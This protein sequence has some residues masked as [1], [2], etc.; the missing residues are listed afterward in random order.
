MKGMRRRLAAVFA[1][2]WLAIDLAGCASSTVGGE[3]QQKLRDQIRDRGLDPE[4]IIVPFSL[5]PDMHAWLK[6]NVQHAG[7]Q[8]ERLKALLRTIV[9]SA[10]LGVSYQA[11]L[12]ITA[13]DVFRT[14]KANCLAFTNLFVG[15]ARELGVEVYFLLV[16]DLQ[17]F[18]REGDLVVVSDHMTAAFG[19]PPDR[20]VLD[21]TPGEVREYRET[22]E[23]TDLVAVAMYYTN[24]G[25]G[26][27]RSGDEPAALEWLETAAKL[28]PELAGAWTNLGVARRR[29]GDITGAEEA[30]RRALEADASALSAYQNLAALLR[31]RGQEQE[32]NE[33][34]A[35]TARRDNRNPFTFLDLGD[36]S[37]RY[38]RLQEAET[39]YR[40]ALSLDRES[41]EPYAA[42]GLLRLNSGNAKDARGWLRKAQ[43]R[44]PK[45]DRVLR[46]ERM[47]ERNGTAGSRALRAGNESPTG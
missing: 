40:R 27:L 20:L 19:R 12:T 44:D 34:L 11:D 41:P 3:A 33:L 47:L 31:L 15:M 29:T 42:I 16:E 13:E 35:L 7:T 25:A 5:T 28:A 6:D 14:R 45:N 24:R 4:Q 22:R 17:S 46:L 1:V 26:F 30:Y 8:Q 18:S 36:L 37:L 23:L 9:S 10:G 39:Y 38:G 43:G 32:A 21:F 2:A